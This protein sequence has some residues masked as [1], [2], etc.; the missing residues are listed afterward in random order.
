M[1]NSPQVLMKVN[2]YF[3]ENKKIPHPNITIELGGKFNLPFL[4]T[5]PEFH[6][7]L[8]QKAIKIFSKMNFENMR[9]VINDIFHTRN[10]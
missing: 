4:D 1:I 7:K 9:N 2:R 3:C 5:F 6:I 8:R 10:M